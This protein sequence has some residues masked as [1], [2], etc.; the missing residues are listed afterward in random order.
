M[1]SFRLIWISNLRLQRNP[2]NGL[3]PP[4]RVLSNWKMVTQSEQQQ[5]Q[6]NGNVSDMERKASVESTVRIIEKQNESVAGPIATDILT[7]DPKRLIFLR[8]F[9]KFIN[10]NWKTCWNRICITIHK[11]SDKQK[12]LSW[13]L[14]RKIFLQMVCFT[15]PSLDYYHLFE[16]KKSLFKV[17]WQWLCIC[18]FKRFSSCSY[19]LQI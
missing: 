11:F 12:T 19:F 17:V 15:F 6:Q 16:M 14:K 10:L 7:T 13:F 1:N 8:K 3:S 5:Q 18:W 2:I 9:F 4:D